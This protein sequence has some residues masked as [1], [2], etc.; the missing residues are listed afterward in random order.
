MRAEDKYVCHLKSC[1]R[2]QRQAR[3]IWENLQSVKKA[4]ESK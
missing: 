4:G 2:N 3:Y 1:L